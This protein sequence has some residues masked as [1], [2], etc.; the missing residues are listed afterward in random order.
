MSGNLTSPSRLL[1]LSVVVRLLRLLVDRMRLT[2]LASLLV[3]VGLLPAEVVIEAI[4][5]RNFIFD[6]RC[7]KY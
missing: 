1:L 7:L 5:N 3:R 6:K 4:I 2:R